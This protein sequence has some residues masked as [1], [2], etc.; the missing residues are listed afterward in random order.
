MTTIF[1]PPVIDYD[2]GHGRIERRVIQTSTALFE[3]LT[4]PYAAQVFRIHRT[5]MDLDGQNPR[6]DV[7]Y[8]ITSL[9]PDQAGPERLLKLARGHWRIEN[10]LHWV[11]DVTFDEDR[12]QVRTGSGPRVLATLRN[13]AIS[14]FRLSGVDN[15]AQALRYCSRDPQRPLRL[16][17]AC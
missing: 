13:L 9:S 16:I 2:K 3:Y 1:P 5:T 12:S 6:D 10:S 14:I 15:I 4:F 17:G 7:V 8:G 11:R